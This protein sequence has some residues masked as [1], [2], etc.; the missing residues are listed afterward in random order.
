MRIIK[1]A[2]YFIHEIIGLLLFVIF[3]LAKILIFSFSAL[4]IICSIWAVIKGVIAG[5][6]LL[7]FATIK[8]VLF[9]TITYFI[10]KLLFNIASLFCTLFGNAT[11]LASFIS[12]RIVI[13]TNYLPW[14]RN[15]L[16]E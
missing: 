12:L 16:R 2:L 3:F 5:E 8:A 7:S 1:A 13:L 9:C 10:S 14:N 6:A 11:D 4:L 15:G